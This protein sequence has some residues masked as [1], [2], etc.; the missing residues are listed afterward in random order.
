MAAIVVDFFQNIGML[1]SDFCLHPSTIP[2]NNFF[3]SVY[4]NSGF[5]LKGAFDISSL[6]KRNQAVAFVFSELV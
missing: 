4:G 2:I 3:Y 6:R 5:T 1:K